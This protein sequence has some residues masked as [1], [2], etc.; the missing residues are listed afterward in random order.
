M[1]ARGRSK[2]WKAAWTAASETA[3]ALLF[4]PR[5][6]HCGAFEDYLCPRCRAELEPVG[7]DVCQRCGAPHGRPP[8]AGS[9]AACGHCLTA[10]FPFRAARSAFVYRGP[11]RSLVAACKG[12]GLRV[13]ADSMA[14]LAADSFDTLARRA[15][16]RSGRVL[17]TWVPAHESADRRRGYNHAEVFARAL[18][19]GAQF[20]DGTESGALLR[21]EARRLCSKV[22][23]TVAQHGLDRRARQHNLRG[24][25]AA[26]DWDGAEAEGV[27]LVDDVFTTGATAAEVAR[28]LVDA[29][30]PPVYVFT[31]SRTPGGTVVMRD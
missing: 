3:A 15:G 8:A 20:D 23:R 6:V 12:G 18:V 30:F 28:V 16:G 21:L 31:F 24:A 10:G 5:C 27:I 4:P 29:G 19:A 22:Q 26:V 25:F 17:V 13:V 9:A 1:K 7:E 11:A 14:R 2:F